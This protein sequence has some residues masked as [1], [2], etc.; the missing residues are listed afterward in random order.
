MASISAPFTTLLLL[1]LATRAVL[2]VAGQ[3]IPD[4]YKCYNKDFQFLPTDWKQALVDEAPA[5]SVDLP[6]ASTCLRLCLAEHCT[7]R[8]FLAGVWESKVSST[9]PLTIVTH[10]S[11]SRWKQLRGQCRSWK[12]PLVASVYIHIEQAGGEWL[13][14]ENEQIVKDSMRQ[15]QKMHQS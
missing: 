13:S 6:A 3:D 5:R 7:F 4:A 14:N 2:L 9:L 11:H 15:L 10:T 12:G 8:L 1:V